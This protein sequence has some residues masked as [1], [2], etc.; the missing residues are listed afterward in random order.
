MQ[1]GDHERILLG[2]GVFGFGLGAVGD[3]ALFHHVLQWH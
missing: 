2:G 3:V 1:F